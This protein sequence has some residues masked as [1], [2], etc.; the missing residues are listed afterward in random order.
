[1]LHDVV[2]VVV[3]AEVLGREIVVGPFVHGVHAPVDPGD[4]DV[5][6]AAVGGGSSEGVLE[7]GHELVADVLTEDA[8]AVVRVIP[9]VVQAGVEDEGVEA[10]GG[11]VS[12]GDPGLVEDVVAQVTVA[13]NLRRMESLLLFQRPVDEPPTIWTVPSIWKPRFVLVIGGIAVGLMYSMEQSRST[14]S[15]EM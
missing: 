10:V 5:H 11:L 15:P 6:V 12:E 1:M 7:V 8:L 13:V 3:A 2:V 14:P 4:V 9:D